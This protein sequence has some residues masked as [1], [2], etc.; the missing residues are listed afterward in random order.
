VSR[1][2]GCW[3]CGSHSR[4]YSDCECAKCVDPEGYREWRQESPE[5]YRE[6]LD[7][8]RLEHDEECDCPSC[9]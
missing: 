2:R 7:D 8:Q 4:C 3:S 6:W 9:W 1:I 5:E